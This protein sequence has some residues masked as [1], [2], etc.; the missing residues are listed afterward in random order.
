MTGTESGN[1]RDQSGGRDRGYDFLGLSR[2]FDLTVSEIGS[3]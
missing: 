1:R 3:H 2:D